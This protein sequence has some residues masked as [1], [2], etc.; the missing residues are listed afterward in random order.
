M[1]YVKLR[2]STL[3]IDHDSPILFDFLTRLMMLLLIYIIVRVK[4]NSIIGTLWKWCQYFITIVLHVNISQPQ[5]PFVSMGVAPM[6]LFFYCSVYRRS[7]NVAALPQREN[8]RAKNKRRR[9]R[10]NKRKK[11]MKIYI[12]GCRDRPATCWCCWCIRDFFVFNLLEWKFK[13]IEVDPETQ[14]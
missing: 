1:I 5:E 12:L 2:W 10:R 11:E 14:E 13:P 4:Y 3:L 6:T 9:W 7:F 8:V